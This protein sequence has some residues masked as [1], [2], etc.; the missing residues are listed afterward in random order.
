MSDDAMTEGIDPNAD[1]NN[2]TVDRFYQSAGP[3]FGITMCRRPLEVA[4]LP[5]AGRCPC[6]GPATL[7]ST[8][9]LATTGKMVLLCDPCWQ[10]L[11]NLSLQAAPTEPTR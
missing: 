7:Y 2:L 5:N 9:L 3:L 10:R 4:N 1:P 8:D 11:V 6:G